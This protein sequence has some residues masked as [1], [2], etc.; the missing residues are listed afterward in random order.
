MADY[1]LPEV[2]ILDVWRGD[3]FQ[4]VRNEHIDGKCTGICKDC[5]G[6]QTA[7]WNISYERAIEIAGGKL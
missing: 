7:H 2:T 3:L 4:E 5:E 1:N 6:W